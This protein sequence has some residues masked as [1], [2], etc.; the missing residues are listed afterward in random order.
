MMLRYLLIFSSISLVT[1]GYSLDRDIFTKKIAESP[2]AWMT[3]QIEKDLRSYEERGIYEEDLDKAREFFKNSPITL[4][5]KIIG[6]KVFFYNYEKTFPVLIGPR[7]YDRL[8]AVKHLLKFLVDYS[9]LPNVDFILSLEDGIIKPTPAPVM[10]FGKNKYVNSLVAFPDFQ[11]LNGYKSM[12]KTVK[13]ATNDYPFY[14]KSPKAF[15]RGST[16][17][18]G[19]YTL[20]NWKEHPRSAL[21]LFSKQHPDILD[22]KFTNVVSNPYKS[23]IE[24]ELTRSHLLS[25]NISVHDHLAFKYL[26]DIDGN[27]CTYSRLF[28]ILLSNSLCFK[29]DSDNEQWYYGALEPYIHYIPFKK[30]LSDLIEK[31]NWAENHEEEVKTII[32]NANQFVH[33]HLMQE[34]AFQYVYELLKAYAKLQRFEPKL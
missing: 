6:H 8:K 9:D 4:R 27:N 17:G 5:C 16:T 26:I 3:R 32:N 18:G 21:V 13:E 30:D 31:I 23:S 34:D 15:W 24:K 12:I 20:S 2:P 33:T 19:C 10:T 1:I 28:W 29:E 22:A 25:K 14:K 7:G 11:A